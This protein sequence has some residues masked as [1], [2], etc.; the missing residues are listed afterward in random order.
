MEDR[1]FLLGD[2]E[3]C[4][5]CLACQAACPS[6]DINFVPFQHKNGRLSWRERNRIVEYP[7]RMCSVCLEPGKRP[8]CIEVCPEQALRMVNVRQEKQAKN[9]QAVNYLYKY[10][11]GRKRV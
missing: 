5:Q 8:A 2:G 11:G 6:G 10:W 1:S 7:G 9:K 3:K 4:R